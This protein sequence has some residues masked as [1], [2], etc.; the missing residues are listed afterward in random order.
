[1]LDRHQL[2]ERGCVLSKS[3]KPNAET[4]H[5]RG[6]HSCKGEFAKTP[7]ASHSDDAVP[8]QGARLNVRNTNALETVPDETEDDARTLYCQWDAHGGRFKLF[9]KSVLES[10]SYMFAHLQSH[11]KAGG[12]SSGK[13]LER[14]VRDKHICVKDRADHELRCLSDVFEEAA[15]VLISSILGALACLEVAARRLNLMVDADKQGDAPSYVNAKC[16]T[17]LAETDEI[18]APGLRAHMSRRAREDWE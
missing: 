10:G 4:G 2:E 8:D 13:W 5:G 17:P 1:M 12:S 14:L 3:P 18:F 7:R 15:R 9:R 16:L 11:G 6:P